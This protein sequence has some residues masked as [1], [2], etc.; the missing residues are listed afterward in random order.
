MN[1]N[2]LLNTDSYKA[3]HYLQY[4][5]ATENV[6]CYIESR[7]GEFEE[8]VFFGLQ[9]FLKSMLM[10]PISKHDIDEAAA[11]FE[12]HGLCFHREGWEYILH[13]HAGRLPVAIEAVAEGTVVQTSNVLLQIEATDPKCFWLPSYLE[14]AL[15]RAI[16]YPTTVATLSW[17]V[18]QLLH[19]YLTATADNTD[20]LDFQL[21]DFGARGSSSQ[22]SA[23]VAGAAHL[24]SFKGTD[25]ISGI[26]AAQT[27]YQAAMP[28]FSIPAA[29]HSTMTAWGKENETAAYKNMFTQFAGEGNLFAVVTDSYDIWHALE[30]IWGDALF[31]IVKNNPGR[32]IIRPD[33]GDPHTVPAKVIEILMQRFGYHTNSKGYKVLPD[34]LRVIQ[35]DGVNITSIAECCEH[36]KSKGISTENLCFGMG[37]ALH[38]R[39]N[40]DTQRFAMKANAVQIS[41]KWIPIQKAPITDRNKASKAGRLALVK[42]N[43]GYQTITKDEC[44]Q[45]NQL[46]PVYRDGTLLI[47]DSFECIQQRARR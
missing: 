24:I 9:M 47:D 44:V 14:T 41:G 15:L 22:E 33:S 38:Q 13:Q 17:H 37:G 34:N 46:R 43:T 10:T 29:E 1:K 42:G 12:A 16:W 4:P 20:L 39:I 21:H 36:L 28:G 5:P 32:C 45:D 27:F 40:R 25:T 30:N 2:I 31:D 18:R 7:G 6:S 3:S 19:S 8:T 11:I 26:V 23:S 35:G